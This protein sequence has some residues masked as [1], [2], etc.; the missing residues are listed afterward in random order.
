[1]PV[2]KKKDKIFVLA[3]GALILLIAVF[4]LWMLGSFTMR[5]F[6]AGKG[7]IAEMTGDIVTADDSG[8]KDPLITSAQ[9][10]YYN[11]FKT[12]DPLRGTEEARL[13]ILEFGD[14]QCPY[15]AEMDE[16]L[17]TI[18]EEYNGK[19]SLVWKDF[20]NPI[21]LEGRGA[22]LAARCAGEQN[23]FWEYHDYLYANQENLGRE[24]YNKIAVELQLDLAE[25][26]SCVEKQKYVELI[27]Q[28]LLDGQKL[29]VDGTP[30]LF[31]GDTTIDQVISE[32]ELRG[33]INKEII[34]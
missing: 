22:A 10:V 15:S 24:L 20:V 8:F 11:L 32:E 27:G 7:P 21:H 14:F 33:I 17:K 29:E 6:E 1:M 30:Y 26:N 3:V 16:V 9:D 25:F 18:L 23:K 13:F 34:N 4:F 28:G 12:T 31:I 5:A 19:V 2:S